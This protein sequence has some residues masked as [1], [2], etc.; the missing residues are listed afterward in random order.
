[1]RQTFEL[2]KTIHK[3][4]TDTI[5]VLNAFTLQSHICGDLT[6]ELNRIDAALWVI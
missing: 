6:A 1:M 5:D 2:E 4:V 3:P